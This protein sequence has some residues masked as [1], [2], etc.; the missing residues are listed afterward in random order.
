MRRSMAVLLALLMVMTAVPS[1]AE[2]TTVTGVGNGIGGEMQLAVTF[3]G[4]QITAIETVSMQDT[5]GVYDQA[6][7][8]ISAEVLAGQTLNVDTVA[9]ATMSSRGILAALKDAAGQVGLLEKLE[10][11]DK[12]ERSIGGAYV[13]E[14]DVIVVGAGLAGVSAAMNAAGNG[15]K[16]VLLEKQ[17]VIGGSSI[18]AVGAFNGGT[19]GSINMTAL[20]TEAA[21]LNGGSAEDIDL[22]KIAA[23]E[24]EVP[25]ALAWMNGR[26]YLGGVTLYSWN[27]YAYLDC[28]GI[29]PQVEGSPWNI[30]ASIGVDMET[31]QLVACDGLFSVLRQQLEADENIHLYYETPAV[32]LVTDAAGAVTGVVAEHN[33]ERVTFTA[34]SV[35]LACGGA[36]ANPS[37]LRA[38]D[39]GDIIYTARG[40]TGDAQLMAEKVGAANFGPQHLLTN[41]ARL[42][43]IDLYHSEAE[44]QLLFSGMFVDDSGVRRIRE[45]ALNCIVHGAYLGEG[46][47]HL[48]WI[49]NES[50]LKNNVVPYGGAEIVG[51]N[52]LE[53]VNER[54]EQYGKYY[55]KAD[56]IEELAEKMNMPELVDTFKRYN[57]GCIAGQDEMEKRADYLADMNE[58]PYYCVYAYLVGPGTIGGVVT[59][60]RTRALRADGSVIPGLYVVGEASN[61][62]FFTETYI[63]TDMLSIALTTGRIAAQEA[64]A[65]IE[66]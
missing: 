26:L 39:Q 57:E 24:A 40:A 66:K 56:T 5:K 14:A 50:I 18:L 35:I 44:T 53:V 42:Y 43:P 33:G 15:A 10:G 63:C 8:K 45:D 4:E 17:D 25:A 55:V 41:A 46:Q 31:K 12:A 61:G 52:Y 64:V 7:E 28:A 16:V 49:V 3:D 29:A 20:L 38:E 2:T 9:G 27:A 32:E 1:M 30:S 48:Y 36:G 13:T 62:A 21:S 6:M 58:G 11:A 19:D 22:V 59:D 54:C 65:A 37:L 60:G 23:T 47:D 51:R 34:P